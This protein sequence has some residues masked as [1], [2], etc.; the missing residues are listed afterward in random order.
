MLLFRPPRIACIASRPLKR[1]DLFGAQ[2]CRAQTD[3][4]LIMWF[5]LKCDVLFGFRKCRDCRVP[6]CPE[7]HLYLSIISN[8]SLGL[9]GGN[10]ICDWASAPKKKTSYV[11]CQRAPSVITTRRQCLPVYVLRPAV[12]VV[13]TLK[14]SLYLIIVIMSAFRRCIVHDRSCSILTWIESSKPAI[15]SP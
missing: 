14:R 1:D 2:K 15:V 13:F 10:K 6:L 3:K 12:C 7:I 8:S 11:S 4:R 5:P 9:N